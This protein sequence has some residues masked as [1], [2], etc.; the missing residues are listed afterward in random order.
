MKPNGHSLSTVLSTTHHRATETIDAG[1]KAPHTEIK[2]KSD[3]VHTF[4]PLHTYI[5]TCIGRIMPLLYILHQI[6]GIQSTIATLDFQ[7]L[8]FVSEMMLQLRIFAQ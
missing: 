2:I 3:I 5:R 1:S 7:R 4:P 8:E 6:T